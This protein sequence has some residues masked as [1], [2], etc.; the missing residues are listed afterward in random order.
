MRYRGGMTPTARPLSAAETAAAKELLRSAPFACIAMVEPGGPYV[1]PL[2]FAYAEDR[3]G[4]AGELRGTIYLHTGQGR[5]T[6][7]LAADPRVCLSVTDCVAYNQGN[8]PCAD[9]FSFQSL[10]VWGDAHLIEDGS[11]R[12]AALGAIVAKYDPGATGA[13][14]DEAVLARTLIYE[15]IIQTAAFREQPRRQ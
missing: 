6:E 3:G 7:A 8:S 12:E 2:N 15:V 9:G 1:V 13:S 4:P 10:L 14:F 5:K 11:R